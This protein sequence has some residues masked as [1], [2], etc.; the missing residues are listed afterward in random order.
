MPYPT[1][2]FLRTLADYLKGCTIA[3]SSKVP[4]RHG[5]GAWV[6]VVPIVPVALSVLWQVCLERQ[7]R[8]ERVHDKENMDAERLADLNDRKRERRR[9]VEIDVDKYRWVVY[10]ENAV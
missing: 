10:A 6:W 8:Q 4:M 9:E 5:E 2:R 7:R 1:L 3:R